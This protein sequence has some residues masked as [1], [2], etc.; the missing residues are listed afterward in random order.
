MKT[1]WKYQLNGTE[2]HLSI[3][4]NAKILSAHEQYNKICIWAEVNDSEKYEHRTFVLG[5]TGHELPEGNLQF[6]GTVLIDGGSHVF[7]V[8]ERLNKGRKHE[9]AK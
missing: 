6:I 9:K 2:E 1:I 7:Q 5:G 8:Y 3:P 4:K